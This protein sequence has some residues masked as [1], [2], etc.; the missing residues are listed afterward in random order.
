MQQRNRDGLGNVTIEAALL[1]IN[2]SFVVDHY[3]CGNSQG[4]LTVKGAI[5]QKFR[6]AVGTTGGNTG[7]LK[8]Y[9]YDDRLRFLTPPS[10]I[11]PEQSVDWTIGRETIE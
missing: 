4:T 5:A 10:F 8:N 9:N 6:G 1:A 2:H 11:K 7:Y 3:D